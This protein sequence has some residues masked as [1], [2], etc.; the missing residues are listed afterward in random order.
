[1]ARNAVRMGIPPLLGRPGSSAVAPGINGV[2][3]G[4]AGWHGAYRYVFGNGTTAPS[5]TF[6]VTSDASNLY[7]SFE[8]DYTAGVSPN[9]SILIGLDPNGT[10]ANARRFI[11]YPVDTAQPE[12]SNQSLRISQFYTGPNG[13]TTFVPPAGSFEAKVQ[14]TGGGHWFVEVRLS[15]SAYGIPATGDFGLYVNII[16]INNI[17][18]PTAA[19]YTWP[20]EPSVVTYGSL[21][22]D[23]PALNLWG[24]ASLSGTS[25][26]VSFT[27]MDITTDVPGQPNRIR[28]PGTTYGPNPA[29]TFSVN[30]HN[31]SVDA[32]TNSPVAANGVNATFKIANF[33][34][35]SG[36]DWTPVLTGNNPKAT[37]GDNI[38]A[39]GTRVISTAPWQWSTIPSSTSSNPADPTP[40]SK[41]WYVINYHQCI[42][43]ELSSYGPGGTAF[44]NRSVGRN[45]D[46]GTASTFKQEATISTMGYGTPAG[47]N[48]QHRFSLHIVEQDLGSTLD[49]ERK[50]NVAKYRWIAKGFLHTGK[51]ITI[52]QTTY[53]VVRDVGAFGYEISHILSSTQAEAAWLPVFTGPGLTQMA[54]NHFHM[55]MPPDTTRKVAT[56]ITGTDIPRD[57]KK[58]CATLGVINSF[59]LFAL[60]AALGLVAF[61][62]PH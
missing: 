29:T 56:I 33:G 13:S 39:D 1:M 24:T 62:F 37:P 8:V 50:T 35:P 42:L 48:G 15:R 21:I 53:P 43:V 11:L 27:A 5:A 51:T 57:V 52:N 23:T 60:L 7:F 19:E 9:D 45:M 59:G 14:Y 44:T 46:F 34:L 26:G 18:T 20:D 54:K 32:A 40:K 28:L 6:Q 49:R 2:V 55:D 38:S 36:A 16:P 30:L 10:V 31:N 12:G 58:G 61:K 41:E 3:E 17:A 25:H 4:D 47:N 22:H